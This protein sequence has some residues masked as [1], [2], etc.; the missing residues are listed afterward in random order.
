MNRVILPFEREDVAVD[1]MLEHANWYIMK[2]DE[3]MNFLKDKDN[4]SSMAVLRE[5]NDCLKLEYKHYDKLSIS[6]YI[7]SPEALTYVAE[8][9]SCFVKQNKT[10]SYEWLSSN[11]FD[12][13]DYAFSF[14]N[15]IEFDEFR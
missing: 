13:G 1:E 11:L 15:Y 6:K 9:T 7:N 8:I 10:N 4:K 3:G 5:I 12:V 2:S 14:V